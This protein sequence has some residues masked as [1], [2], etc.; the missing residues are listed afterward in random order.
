MRTIQTE[1]QSMS[2]LLDNTMSVYRDSKYWDRQA[3]ANSIDLDQMPQNV[4]SDQ[5][6]PCLPLLQQ[7]FFWHIICSKK[8]LF[9]F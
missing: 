3:G 4:G 6:L 5:A 2:L 7:F 8:Y 9:K 1:V